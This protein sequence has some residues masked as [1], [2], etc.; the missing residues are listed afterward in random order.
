MDS[1]KNEVLNQTIGSFVLSD[2]VYQTTSETITLTQYQGSSTELY[3]P[4][5]YQDKQIIIKDLSIFS[6]SLESLT[7][8]AVDGQ[9]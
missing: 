2:W 7:L 9:K 1:M 5:K 4:G 8:G 6:S 3:I